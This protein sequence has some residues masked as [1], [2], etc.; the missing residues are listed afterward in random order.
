MGIRHHKP[1]I[2]CDGPNITNVIT[3]SFQFQQ[4]GAHHQRAQREFY[5][6]RAFDGLT[7]RCAMR[8]TRISGNAFRQENSFVYRQ[9][10]EKFFGALMGVEHAKLQIEYGFTCDREVELPRLD[11]SRM[12]R[13]HGHLKDA[14]PQSRTIDVAFSLEGCQLA[15][16]WTVLAQWINSEP[17][18]MQP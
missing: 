10:L 8:E 3:E 12:D 7:E 18:I 11:D 15:I 17:L 13:S 6:G 2:G 1:D 5:P 9:L 14:F 4:D 16:E